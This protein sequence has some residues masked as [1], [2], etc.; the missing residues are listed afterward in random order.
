[1]SSRTYGENSVSR[2][3]IK[4]KNKE[5]KTASYVEAVTS[6]TALQLRLFMNSLHLQLSVITVMNVTDTPLGPADT[7][8]SDKQCF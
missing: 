7:D 8:D 2:N 6:V 3:L 4:K 5:S 1:M